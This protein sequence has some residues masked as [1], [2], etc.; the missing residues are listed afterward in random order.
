MRCGTRA[1]KSHT[2]RIKNCSIIQEVCSCATVLN[3]EYIRLHLSLKTKLLQNSSHLQ[4]SSLS[5][6]GKECNPIQVPLHPGV[7][8]D[9]HCIL[10]FLQ[11]L[12]NRENP[13]QWSVCRLLPFFF[14]VYSESFTYT[15][16][17]RF[18][19]KNIK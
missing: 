14:C 8:G 19:L 15:A 17:V 3:N 11:E 9:P 12:K 4:N 13:S 10:K 16:N 6:L 18:R 2:K 7:S 5:F 1:F